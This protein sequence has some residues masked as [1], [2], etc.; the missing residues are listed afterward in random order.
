MPLCTFVHRWSQQLLASQKRWRFVSITTDELVE[1]YRSILSSVL[2]RNFR[3]PVITAESL[4]YMYP[5]VKRKCYS[6]ASTLVD[7]CVC[8]FREAGQAVKTCQKHGHSCLRTI[9]SFYK[10]PRK[11]H[12]RKL[13]RCLDFLMGEFRSAFDLR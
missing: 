4:P 13:G 2:P 8:A 9:V 6:A 7:V 5:S 12:F 11:K 10:V 1:T 3:A